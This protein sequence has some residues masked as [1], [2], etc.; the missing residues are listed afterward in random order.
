MKEQHNHSMENKKNTLIINFPTMMAG[1]VE[2]YFA[3]LM[4]S[5]IEKGYRVIWITSEPF[6]SKVAFEGLL[7]NPGLEIVLTRSWM[8]YLDTPRIS[9]TEDERVLMF[10]CEPIE[11]ILSDKI[12]TEA[13]T[14][15]FLHYLAIPNFAGKDYFPDQYLKNKGLR[16]LVWRFLHRILNRA[17]ESNCILGFDLKHLVTYEEYYQIPLPDKETKIAPF[18]DAESVR[19]DMENTKARCAERKEKFVITSCARFEF[20]HK[21]YLLGL[22]DAFAKVKEKHSQTVLQLVGYGSGQQELESRIMA[23]PEF[24]RKDIH[25]LGMLSP[26]VLEKYYKSSQLIVGL[27]GSVAKGA[28]CGIPALVVRHYHPDCETYG[29]FEDT[30]EMALC[31]DPGMD[32]VPF[33]EECITMD[34]ELYLQHA[35]N[36]FARE[37]SERDSIITSIEECFEQA[38]KFSPSVVRTS[39]EM[40]VA[41]L[42]YI[43]CCILRK[44]GR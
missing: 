6:L 12:R 43:A 11:Y 8:H 19:F 16:K 31:E 28:Q 17:A 21:A 42:L 24:V 34:P 15:Q 20:P 1:G 9:L 36:G 14:K 3:A 22:V 44:L 27:A 32:I 38:E 29:F 10:T 39:R 25:M 18:F 35:E 30:S 13:G 41:K 37:A 26:D 5:C 33:I 40:L 4:K 23:L 7:D 2:S